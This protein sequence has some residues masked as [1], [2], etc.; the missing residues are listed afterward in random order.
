MHAISKEFKLELAPAKGSTGPKPKIS[1]D[2]DAANATLDYAP[3][4]D[5]LIATRKNPEDAKAAVKLIEAV[6]DTV[7]EQGKNRD[8]AALMFSQNAEKALLAV[9]IQSAAPTT[10]SEIDTILTRCREVVDKL[11][12]EIVQRKGK[13]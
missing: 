13:G 2:D 11:Q 7:S 8:K 6:C 1:F 12:A 4:V 9:D 10:Y 3:L 5:Q